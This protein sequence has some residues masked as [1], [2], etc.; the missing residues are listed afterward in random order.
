VDPLSSFAGLLVPKNRRDPPRGNHQVRMCF[1][2]R[3]DNLYRTPSFAPGPGFAIK[4]DMS[5]NMKMV[6]LQSVV[7]FTLVSV[8]YLY[9][10]QSGQD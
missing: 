9:L 1:R 7:V 10:R 8:L 2:A 3:R 4:T 5:Y 6:L